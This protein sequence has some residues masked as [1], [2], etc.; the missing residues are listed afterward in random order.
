MGLGKSWTEKEDLIIME[1][2]H[3]MNDVALSKLLVGRTPKATKHRRHKLGI[4]NV[5]TP[6]SSGMKW[7]KEED[8]FFI[9]NYGKMS[10]DEMSKHLIGRTRDAIEIHKK[11]LTNQLD[12]PRIRKSSGL[13]WTSE[14]DQFITTNYIN[15]TYEEM[16]E[17]LAG[18]T[19]HAIQMRVQ[20]LGFERDIREVR[21]RRSRVNY[22]D[23]RFFETPDIINSY[24]AGFIAADGNINKFANRVA[25][26]IQRR[27]EYLLKQLKEDSSYT[28]E[29][30]YY[31]GSGKNRDVFYS[32]FRVMGQSR[33]VADLYSNFNLLPKK[34]HILEPPYIEDEKLVISYIR[35]F[36]DGDGFI[37]YKSKNASKKP[38]WIVGACGTK[39][40]MSWL[41]HWFDKWAPDERRKTSAQVNGP[42]N[43]KSYVYTVSG[44]RALRILEKLLSVKTPVYLKRKWDP[45]HAYFHHRLLS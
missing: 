30:R 42:Y 8:D 36:I 31:C 15:L 18:R 33:W 23:E 28:G 40:M 43:S 1:N 24:Y 9:A 44:R 13:V 19:P 20:V 27:D 2:A 10:Y 3:L 38:L 21:R 7:T 35:G 17:H 14:E 34:T 41:K 39:A 32:D 45:V 4:E 11:A 29:I 16:S 22:V 5:R 25:I 12:N 6:K 37:S 26:R